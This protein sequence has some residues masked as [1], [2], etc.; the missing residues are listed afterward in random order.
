MLLCDGKVVSR[1]DV[2]ASRSS[3]IIFIFSSDIC[4]YTLDADVDGVSV[5][6]SAM[7]A[8]STALLG[9]SSSFSSS[10]ISL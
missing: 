5:L 1:T 9:G 6:Q 3:L 2:E 8:T 7:I 10:G 4:I